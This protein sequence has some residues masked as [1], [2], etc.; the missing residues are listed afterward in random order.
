M[1]VAL[2]AIGIACGRSATGTDAASSEI[3]DVAARVAQVAAA[4]TG[5]DAPLADDRLDGNHLGFD[6]HTYPGDKTMRAWKSA[7]RAPYSWVGF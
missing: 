2:G 7:P 4:V 6:T 1:L 3:A 5:Q